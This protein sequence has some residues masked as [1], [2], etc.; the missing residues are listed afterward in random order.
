MIGFRL[1]FRYIASQ[2]WTV[3]AAMAGVLAGCAVQPPPQ[4]TP[5]QILSRLPSSSAAPAPLSDAEK[6][7]Y[8]QID[9]QVMA[10]QVQRE[11]QRAWADAWAAAPV[12][13]GGYTY[14]SGPYPAYPAYYPAYPAVA[15][16]P[17][18]PAYP[19]APGW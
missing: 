11:K 14:Y 19:L 9:K 6:Q 15:P 3:A 17:L 12:Y 5:G 18:Y 10:D 1:P 2:R 8:Q 16:A 13:Y 7:R 4:G